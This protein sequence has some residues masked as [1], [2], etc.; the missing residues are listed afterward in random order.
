MPELL[1]GVNFGSNVKEVIKNQECQV[2]KVENETGEGVM[3][4]YQVFP[5]VAVMYNDFHMSYCIS[6]FEAKDTNLLC[7][8]HCREGGMEQPM[9]ANGYS[10]REAGDL[11]VDIRKYH[12]GR[13]N[14]PLKHFHGISIAFYLPEAEG[15]L[16]KELKEFPVKLKEI[17]AK[18]CE[19]GKPYVIK[20]SQEIEHIFSELYYVPTKIRKEYF[21]IKIFELLLY[22][23]ALELNEQGKE[24]PYFYKSQVETVKAIWMEMTEDL[25]KSYTIEELAK[26]Y[27]ISATALKTCFRAVYG[28][29]MNTYMQQYRINTAATML[30]KEPRKTVVEIAGEVG[31]ESPSKFSA[32]FKKIIGTTPLEYRKHRRRDL[33]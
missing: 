21:R 25:T 3:T 32:T 4:T 14:F 10:Y 8:D 29:P 30:Q 26:K 19:D 23:D 18:F 16:T 33:R 20:A 5:G 28:S 2:M 12:K 1:K 31:Y 15:Q 7:I 24:K 6:E 11:V 27:E 13:T 9:D 17:Q 22:L